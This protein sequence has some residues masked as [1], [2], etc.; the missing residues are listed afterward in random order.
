M[1]NVRVKLQGVS[2]RRKRV[3]CV[4]CAEKGSSPARHRAPRGSGNVERRIPCRFE[5]SQ[6]RLDVGQEVV[7]PD[8]YFGQGRDLLSHMFCAVSIG[9]PCDALGL[10]GRT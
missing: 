6:S 4:D 5:S 10:R 1:P 3:Y 7:P 9:H 8:K 2:R